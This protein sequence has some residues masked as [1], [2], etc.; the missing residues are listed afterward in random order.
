MFPGF[1]TKGALRRPAKTEQISGAGAG[2]T[3]SAD[4]TKVTA[5]G[6][7]VFLPRPSYLFEIHVVVADPSINPTN[8]CFVAAHPGGKLN[9]SAATTSFVRAGSA[10]F[11]GGY[12]YFMSVGPDEWVGFELPAAIGNTA[13]FSEGVFANG[14]F[15]S[16]QG[17]FITT[18]GT[19]RWAAVTSG[20][21]I[22]KF[23]ISQANALRFQDTS[24]V[25][26]LIF[27]TASTRMEF[28]Q[29]AQ[30]DSTVNTNGA[31]NVNSN[32]AFGASTSQSVSSVTASS[33]GG[34]TG[35]AAVINAATIQK[36][37]TFSGAAVDHASVSLPVPMDGGRELLFINETTKII[38]IFVDATFVIDDLGSGNPFFLA[39][40]EM[41]LFVRNIAGTAYTTLRTGLMTTSL[42]ATGATQGA[43]A[44]LKT[45]RNII[46]TG[47]G[48]SVK[49]PAIVKVGQVV[50]LFALAPI[51]TA[52]LFP[53]SGGNIN[54]IGT[55]TGKTIQFATGS[56]IR[57]LATAVSTTDWH[58]SYVPTF[59][60]AQDAYFPG[61]L[62]VNGN[63]IFG[64]GI[65]TA[66]R[67]S[68]VQGG[69][70]ANWIIGSAGLAESVWLGEGTTRYINLD[71]SALTVEV[72][73]DL[74]TR[75]AQNNTIN[76]GTST[77]QWKEAHARRL[78]STGTSLTNTDWSAS[79]GWGTGAAI[80][81]TTGDDAHGTVTVTSGTSTA[82]DPTL[83]LTFKDGT[84]TNAPFAMSKITAP[85]T[86]LMNPT[87][88]TTTATTLVIQFIGTPQASTIYTFKF[89]NYGV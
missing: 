63:V 35:P 39:P 78:H 84:W 51:N 79:A 80:T 19:I 45:G 15:S 33:G 2:S 48:L 36:I 38:D 9:G 4:Y 62:S 56:G 49:L 66:S 25:D 20:N 42:A 70:G 26:Y 72:G 8:G 60:A 18:G 31:L 13:K 58:A 7:T 28:K 83:T 46:T 77:R 24:L 57:I 85:T 22:A 10:G 14:D 43:A 29:I 5:N 44:Q 54:G 37:N 73:K 27:N 65:L 71:T 47:D 32:V 86:D 21:N 88:E 55:N 87:V 40:G 17:G 11:F 76:L 59:T 67:L 81:S 34:Y 74:I 3:I 69:T 23:P 41:A 50:E 75:S 30:F 53:Q 61:T 1:T 64:N 6:G 89:M 52:I 16:N 82:A 68:L 12:G